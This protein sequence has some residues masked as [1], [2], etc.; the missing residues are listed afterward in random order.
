MLVH[1]WLDSGHHSRSPPPPPFHHPHYCHQKEFLVISLCTSLA[2]D[3][4]GL[5]EHLIGRVHSV[6]WREQVSGILVSVAG[7][8][9]PQLTKTQWPILQTWG[10]GSGLPLPK[11]QPLISRHKVLMFSTIRLSLMTLLKENVEQIYEFQERLDMGAEKF[12]TTE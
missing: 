6:D 7:G 3:S 10:P 4:V 12:R 1:P 5:N 8:G 2:K 11:P 9:A